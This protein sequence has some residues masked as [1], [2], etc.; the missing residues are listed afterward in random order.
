MHVIICNGTSTVTLACVT[1]CS[2]KVSVFSIM[3]LLLVAK[4]CTCVYYLA[5][6][7]ALAFFKV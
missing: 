5:F 6:E 2:L 3:L 4:G 7:I 1:V